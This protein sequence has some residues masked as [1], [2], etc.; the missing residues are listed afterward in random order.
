MFPRQLV[1][2]CVGGFLVP[3][4]AESAS[5]APVQV[6]TRLY[7]A[8]RVAE[9]VK[10]AA[11]RV[12]T[13]ALRAGGIDLRWRN[14]DVADSCAMAPGRRELIVRL[15]RSPAQIAA[16]T[17][18][19]PRTDTTPL[20]L[21]EAFIDTR[22]RAGVLA[23]V[24]VDRVELIAGL[25]ETDATLLLGHAIAHELGHL[26]LGT[27]AHS[28]SGLMRAQWSSADIRRRARADWMLTTEDAAAIWKRLH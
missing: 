22:E 6:T 15:V 8:A 28:V 16:R 18:S 9:T 26:L 24:F 10:E 27:N 4:V 3:P 17:S 21:G 13:G 25:S 7:N 2:I 1:L 14:C 23:T 20:V 5:P 12:A 19:A 11:L